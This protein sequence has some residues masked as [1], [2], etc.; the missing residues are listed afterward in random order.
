M[1]FEEVME[2]DEDTESLLADLTTPLWRIALTRLYL[3]KGRYIPDT[4]KRHGCSFGFC[5][6]DGNQVEMAKATHIGWTAGPAKEPV[7]HADGA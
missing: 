3:K 5:D 2:R 1:K 4:A 7:E 6:A